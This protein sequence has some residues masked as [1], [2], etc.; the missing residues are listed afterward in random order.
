MTLVISSGLYVIYSQKDHKFIKYFRIFIYMLLGALIYIF[1]D[2]N[3]FFNSY[4]F[5][6][7]LM[8]FKPQEA[9]YIIFTGFDFMYVMLVSAVLLFNK[10]EKYIK[11]K[12]GKVNLSL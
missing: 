5:Y 3:I 12:I 10:P 2:H 8:E 1:F 11:L 9:F 4:H 7:D 6:T